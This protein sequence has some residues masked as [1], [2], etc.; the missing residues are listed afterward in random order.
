MTEGAGGRPSSHVKTREKPPVESMKLHDLLGC[1]GAATILL[2]ASA[3]IPLIGPFFSLVT[4]LPFLY[5]ST[6][7]GVNQGVKLVCITVL[8]SALISALLKY[9]QLIF[10]CLEFSFMGLIMAEIYRRNWSIGLSVLVAT[11]SVLLIGL[12]VLTIAGLRQN[13]GPLEMVYAYVE[14]S[15]RQSVQVYENI[16]ASP[17]KAQEFG[18]YL[19]IV[20]NVISRIY[21]SLLIIGTGFVVWFNIIV[22]RPIFQMRNLAY[23]PYGALDRWRSHEFMIWGVIA[24]GFSLFLPLSSIRWFATNALIVMMAVYIFQG[25]SILVFF[26]NEYRVPP[27]IRFGVYFLILFQQVFIIGLAVAGLFD[28]WIDFRRIHSRK[29]E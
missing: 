5:Y 26:L 20:A 29:A 14:N 16:G 24:A 7:L 25:L 28:Q 13:M 9:P 6:K 4:P 8:L 22:S 17:E 3:L 19:T 18:E 1:V 27:W 12:I 15:L 23:P 10:L 11:S 2:L 21:P